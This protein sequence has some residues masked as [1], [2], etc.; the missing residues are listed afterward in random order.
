M[1]KVP[2]LRFKEFSDEWEEKKLED[3]G[4]INPKSKS[5]PKKFVYIDLESVVDGQLKEKKIIEKEEAPSR[6]KRLVEKNDI[7]YQMV[8]PYQQNNLY[9]SFND[10]LDYVASTGYAQIRTFYHNNSMYVYHLMHTKKF[11]DKVLERC[12]G[13]SYPAINSEDLSN[14]S[15]KISKNINEQEKIANFLSSIDKKI[16]LTEEK[17]ELFREYKKGVMQKI[18]SQ[19]LRFKDNNGNDYPEWEE[20]EVGSLLTESKILPKYQDLEKRITVKLNLKGIEKRKITPEEKEGA[21]TNYLRKE[22]QFIYGKQNFHKGAF[23]IIP[24]ELDGFQS[25]SDIPSFDFNFD[26]ICPKYFFYY[27]SQEIVYKNLENIAS[28]TGSKR[29]QPKI[30][31][32]EILSLPTLE[33]QEKIADFLSSIDSKIESIE[34]ELEGLKEFKKGLLQQMFV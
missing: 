14:I 19:E 9:F 5:I 6:A 34:K 13:T 11:L 16:S 27:F 21:T 25:S 18:F 4:E 29:I 8:R 24:K 20:K 10:E 1:R 22:G 32:K 7:L 33:E 28:G 30:F 31:F 2:K 17:L 15:I 3:I 23:G 26:L 12:T